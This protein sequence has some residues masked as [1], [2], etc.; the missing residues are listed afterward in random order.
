[1]EAGTG[2]DRADYLIVG[3][4]R[5]PHG[6]RG[7]LL[8]AVDTDRPQSVFRTGRAIQ[9]GDVDGEP[10][11]AK[12]RIGRLRPTTGGG[13]LKLDGVESRE[14]AEALRGHTLL[15]AA[16]A[17]S[18]AATDEVHYHDLVGLAVR[19]RDGD[20]GRVTDIL[21]FPGGE[22]LVIQVPDG[23]EILI[24]FAKEFVTGIDLKAEVVTIDPP[25]GL[26]DL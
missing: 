21:G 18:P 24:P 26:L 1:M 9:L 16:T 3:R 4:I 6:I 10:N 2:S 23:R 7:E 11:G 5:R 12:Y 14:G 25:E 22:T 8:I 19:T 13:I 20:L 17:A 15:I